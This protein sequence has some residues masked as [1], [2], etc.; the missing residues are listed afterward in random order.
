MVFLKKEWKTLL[1]ALWLVVLTY[2]MIRFDG[3]LSDLNRQGAQ[4]LSTLDTVESVAIGTD[5][6]IAEM[7]KKVDVI[8]SNVEFVVTRIRRR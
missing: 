7:G 4:I 6:N 8:N 2:F 3:Q 1:F 5:A